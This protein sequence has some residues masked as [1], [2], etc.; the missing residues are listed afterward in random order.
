V[1]TKEEGD[2]FERERDISLGWR[3]TEELGYAH[4]LLHKYYSKM[5]DW[6]N[7]GIGN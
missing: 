3:R 1:E 4:L 2:R 6:E 7:I 5:Y